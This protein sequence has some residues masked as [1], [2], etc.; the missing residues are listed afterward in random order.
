MSFFGVNLS[1]EKLLA[2][3][4]YTIKIRNSTTYVLLNWALEAS[5]DNEDYIVIDQRKFWD[6]NDSHF[7]YQCQME[8]EA[9]KERGATSTYAIDQQRLQCILNQR[10]IKG[11]CY[12][13]IKQ[14]SKN[15]HGSDNLNLSGFELYGKTFGNGWI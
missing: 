10:Q 1:K 15:S 3:T 7:S 5:I 14:I 9:L 2:P 13:R 4:C 11:F 8:R 6:E 12:F